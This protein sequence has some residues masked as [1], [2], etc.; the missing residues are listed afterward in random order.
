M[1]LMFYKEEVKVT[2][3]PA[4]SCTIL[5]RAFILKASSSF[6]RTEVAGRVFGLQ[7]IFNDEKIHENFPRTDNKKG[8][9]DD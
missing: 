4:S 3:E 2:I 9:Y 1:G 8:S 5:S 6:C 7:Q